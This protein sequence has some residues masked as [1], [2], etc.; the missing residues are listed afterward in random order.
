[1][2]EYFDNNHNNNHSENISKSRDKKIINSKKNE[3]KLR[4]I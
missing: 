2:I 1:M 3:L 4:I